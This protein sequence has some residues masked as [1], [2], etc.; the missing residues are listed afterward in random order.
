VGRSHIQDVDLQNFSKL[1]VMK[2]EK[3]RGDYGYFLTL[4]NISCLLT[5]NIEVNS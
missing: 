1:T 4:R 3:R 2:R 5:Q